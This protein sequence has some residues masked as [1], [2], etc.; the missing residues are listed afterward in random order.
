MYRRT[1]VTLYD[2]K[3]THDAL[4]G[5]CAT[6]ARPVLPPLHPGS[7]PGSRSGRASRDTKVP[8]GMT[9]NPS[10]DKP[11]YATVLSLREV[12]RKV[13]ASADRIGRTLQARSQ[14]KALVGIGPCTPHGEHRIYVMFVYYTP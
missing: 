12:L 8:R 1:Q 3:V 11:T 14:V 4:D 13:R 2:Y 7:K 6:V 9:S 5:S 10:C